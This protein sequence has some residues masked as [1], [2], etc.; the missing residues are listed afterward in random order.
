MAVLASATGL[1]VEA[2]ATGQAEE[3]I[4]SEAG[5]SR[6]AVAETG[7]PS[8]V[9]P[10]VTTD[11]ALAAA[12]AAVPPAWDLEVEAASVVVEV[13]VAGRTSNRRTTDYRSTK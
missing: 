12:V 11:R 7:M 4:A 2:L 13:G 5:M 9:V 6:A 3:P 8:E 10:G 1:A